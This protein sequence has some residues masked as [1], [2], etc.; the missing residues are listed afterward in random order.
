MF[1]LPRLNLHEKLGISCV[2]VCGFLFLIL[3]KTLKRQHI[4]VKPIAAG[5]HQ[6]PSMEADQ[7]QGR[8]ARP[9]RRKPVRKRLPL[10]RPPHPVR[11]L[12][13]QFQVSLSKPVVPIGI[14]LNGLTDTVGYTLDD[15]TNFPTML[16]LTV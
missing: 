5:I 7:R 3:V 14:P 4:N 11:L 2:R 12:R 16:D 15:V 10:Q 6:P 1:L 9:G 8:G 13:I